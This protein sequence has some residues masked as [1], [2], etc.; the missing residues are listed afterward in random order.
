MHS[1]KVAL[2]TFIISFCVLA[3]PKVGHG[4]YWIQA[5]IL[6]DL[7]YHPDLRWGPLD[8][9]QEIDYIQDGW[10]ASCH[11]VSNHSDPDSPWFYHGANP[12]FFPSSSDGIWG[13]PQ[14]SFCKTPPPKIPFFPSLVKLSLLAAAFHFNWLMPLCL[15]WI[16]YDK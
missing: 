6:G 5:K 8:V 1:C 7:G 9:E 13:D 15:L 16:C 3:R 12:P 11:S 14:A 10:T 4:L 2:T